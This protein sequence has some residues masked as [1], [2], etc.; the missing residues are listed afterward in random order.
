M[1]H[2]CNWRDTDDLKSSTLETLPVRIWHVALNAR[3]R[4][5]AAQIG[6]EMIYLQSLLRQASSEIYINYYDLHLLDNRLSRLLI[7]NEAAEC[8][9]TLNKRAI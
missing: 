4:V 1:R 5:I 2:W 7:R 3:E 9:D 6:S 8:A